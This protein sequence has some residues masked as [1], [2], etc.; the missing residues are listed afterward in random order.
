[1]K[2]ILLTLCL[3][4]GGVNAS[5]AGNILLACDDG[6]KFE[7]AA[8]YS[9]IIETLNDGKEFK[10]TPYPGTKGRDFSG[11]TI[12]YILRVTPNFFWVDAKYL[13]G[14]TPWSQK[15]DRRTLTWIYEDT[16]GAVYNQCHKVES[17]PQI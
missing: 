8:D 2:T 11:R 13:N 4:F 17:T 12:S 9:Y 10:Y 15:I 7:I 14:I 1:M 16:P 5:H 3:F 6:G